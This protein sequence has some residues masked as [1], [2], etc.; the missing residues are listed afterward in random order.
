M[1]AICT[2]EKPSIANISI[3]AILIFG[4]IISFIPQYINIIR[5][6]SSEG[7]SFIM[8]GIA[9]LGNLLTAINAGIFK[10]EHILCCENG[11]VPCVK[12]NLATEQLLNAV[13]CSFV[14]YV[15]FLM[16]SKAVPSKVV[17]IRYK[18]AIIF[19][20]IVMILSVI[21]S[22]LAGVL[23]YNFH[24]SGE[25]LFM[26]A[27]IIGSISSILTI[28]Q[29]APQIYTTWKFESPGSLSV[30][31]LLIQ[32]PGSLLVVF[33]FQAI[34]NKASITTWAPFLFAA[35]EQL[36]LIIMCLIYSRKKKSESEMNFFENS[37]E[38]VLKDLSYP[39]SVNYG[40]YED[41]VFLG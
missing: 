37:S 40:E 21:L 4:T 26:Y 10:W 29:W 18:R 1:V 8:L 7:I 28:I 20:I 22:T 15:I 9:L 14:L 17:M 36:I 12:N 16:Y 3:A 13:L 2:Y 32:M 30:I 34:L 11:F 19:F 41:D 38:D 25:T 39:H 5:K 27:M 24:Q 31:M 35:T 6:R 23:F 33:F